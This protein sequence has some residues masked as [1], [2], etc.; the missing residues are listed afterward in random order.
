[1]SAIRVPSTRQIR[2]DITSL[3]T[4]LDV[5]EAAL[6]GKV[7]QADFDA[8]VLRITA[9]EQDLIGIR[10]RLTLLG[11][12]VTNLEIGMKAEQAEPKAGLLVGVDCMAVGH[13]SVS[14]LGIRRFGAGC[15]INGGIAIETMGSGLMIDGGVDWVRSGMGGTHWHA[16]AIAF[17]RRSE[18]WFVGGGLTGQ[19]TLLG[20]K[21]DTFYHTWGVGPEL[22]LGRQSY[23]VGTKK[24]FFVPTFRVAAPFGPVFVEGEQSAKLRPSV[25]L[26]FGLEA[27]LGGR[28][29]RR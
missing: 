10:Y 12:R 16:S 3:Q 13:D 25:E 22:R 9:V 20:E 19:T 6:A 8:A 17:A 27:K 18:G 4:R 2:E 14:D 24:F 29:P 21:G 7:S 5:A 23:R 28:G 1:M 26:G 11:E 15:G